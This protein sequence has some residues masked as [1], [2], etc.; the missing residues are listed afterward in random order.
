ME[1][2]PEDGDNVPRKRNPINDLYRLADI[3]RWHI[4]NIP[5]RQ[6]VAEHSYFVTL[7]AMR[8]AG[9]AGIPVGRVVQW[10]LM[11]D[12]EEAWTGDIPGPLKRT[13]DKGVIPIREMMGDMYVENVAD[14]TRDLVK[15]CD[16]AEAVKY[17]KIHGGES[18]HVQQVHK[19][20]RDSL[21]VKCENI[22]KGWDQFHWDDALAEL[23]FFLGDEGETHIDDYL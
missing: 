17:L 3:S 19:G 10:A 13:M 7:L 16:I 1:D 21:S 5:T 15:I 22:V 9:A 4:V 18:K 23:A 12:G 20:L 6:S 2:R 11:H 14:I 8:M